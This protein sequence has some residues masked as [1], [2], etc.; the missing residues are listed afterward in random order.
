MIDYAIA[1]D[2]T[3]FEARNQVLPKQDKP[4]SELKKFGR[5]PKEEREQ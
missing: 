1:I 2:T 5:K 3:H 4:K